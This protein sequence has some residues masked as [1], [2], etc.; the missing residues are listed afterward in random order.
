MTL[1]TQAEYARHANVHRSQVTRWLQS[2]RI[3][4]DPSGLIDP[5]VADRQRAAS[6]SPMPHHQARKAQFEADKAA[7]GAGMASGIT[8]G[9]I[10]PQNA[11]SGATGATQAD[12]PA[13]E[14]LGAA[15]KLE[16]WKL[17]KAKAERENIALDKEAGALV[18]RAEVELVIADFGATL[19]GLLEG[20]PDRLAAGIARHR[21]D[22]NAIHAEIEGVATDLLTEMSEHMKRKMETA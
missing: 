12:M 5:E 16:T 20:L 22:V 18:E 17:Q 10:G 4:A 15:L 6:E 19:R 1:L 3:Q 13:M 9:Q 8:Q 21:G 7:N 14:K 11:T 2:G